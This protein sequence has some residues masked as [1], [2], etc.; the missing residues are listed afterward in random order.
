MSK[1]GKRII[2]GAQEALDTVRRARELYEAAGND[3]WGLEDEVTRYYYLRLAASSAHTP[4]PH[5]PPPA[6][7][8][9]G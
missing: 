6:T 7:P 3:C 2:A 4:K 1:A 5:Q 9:H 8:E